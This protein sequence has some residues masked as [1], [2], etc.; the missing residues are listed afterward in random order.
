MTNTGRNE[1]LLIVNVQNGFLNPHTKHL[2]ARIEFIASWFDTV[3]V[4]Q[5]YNCPESGS[6]DA[7]SSI[8][9]WAAIAKGSIEFAHAFDVPRGSLIRS[10][11]EYSVVTQDLIETLQGMNIGHVHI[12]GMDTDISIRICASELLAADFDVTV[13]GDY[14]ASTLGPWRHDSA[15]KKM[16]EILA[17]Q[18]KRSAEILRPEPPE[19]WCNKYGK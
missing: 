8:V 19:V 16:S 7:V 11:S 3:I 12:A 18:R 4:S 5:Y 2:P 14:C 6:D 13:H 10:G 17:H 1:A 9:D 15:L